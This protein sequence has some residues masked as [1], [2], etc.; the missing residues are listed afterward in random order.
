MHEQALVLGAE[1][2]SGLEDVLL[3]NGRAVSKMCF[4]I[5]STPVNSQNSGKLVRAECP[6]AAGCLSPYTGTAASL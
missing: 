3:R 6:M 5:D 2:E 4:W 1:R